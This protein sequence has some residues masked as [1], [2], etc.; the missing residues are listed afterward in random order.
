MEIQ[1]RGEIYAWFTVMKFLHIMVILFLHFSCLS[2]EIKSH[3]DLMSWTFC[4]GWKSPYKHPRRLRFLV[5]R[6]CKRLHL[7]CLNGCWMCHCCV[8]YNY[9]SV[10]FPTQLYLLLF[11]VFSGV[12]NFRFIQI[13]HFSIKLIHLH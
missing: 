12:S 4:P 7:R 10:S 5:N 2:C 11:F 9:L 3:Q 1:F 6:L 13:F 8:R